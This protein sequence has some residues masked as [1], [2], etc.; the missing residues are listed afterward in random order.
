MLFILIAA[1]VL[2]IA[3]LVIWSSM[4]R[5]RS[6]DLRQRFGPE[7]E[8]TM[9][10]VGDKPAAE[11]D[12]KERQKRV[13]KLNIRALNP[14]EKEKYQAEWKQIQ[15]NFV[16][17]PSDAVEEANGLIGE[18]MVARGFPV[19][20]FEQ[21]TEDISVFYPSFVSNYRNAYAIAHKNQSSGA[22]TEE[23]R[24]SIVYYRSMFDVLLGTQNTRTSESEKEITT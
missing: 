3:I 16:D 24:Q 15:A 9:Q 7:Y 8:Y 19:S 17:S 6:E 13:S 10:K 5:R 22:S 2:I 11:E 4:N 23:L 14:G 21:R 20:D 12:L 18:V 1:V